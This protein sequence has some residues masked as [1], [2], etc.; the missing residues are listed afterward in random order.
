MIRR[1]VRYALL[2]WVI[3]YFKILSAKSK[4]LVYQFIAPLT[5][6]SLKFNQ[7]DRLTMLEF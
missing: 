1:R 4:T 2:G 6:R 7:A 5:A 3:K